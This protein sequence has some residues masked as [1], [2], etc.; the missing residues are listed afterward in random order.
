MPKTPDLRNEIY[1]YVLEY[2]KTRYEAN[3][4][5]RIKRDTPTTQNFHS[6][7]SIEDFVLSSRKY[8]EAGAHAGKDKNKIKITEVSRRTIRNAV[9]D[10]IKE[11]KIAIFKGSYEFVPHMEESLDQHP[12]LQIAEKIDIT[13]GVPNAMIVLSVAPEYITAVCNYLSALFHR[14]DIVFIPTYNKILCMN[15]LPKEA[16]DNPSII[17]STK[18]ASTM[19][20]ERIKTALHQFNY[21]YPNFRYKSFYEFAYHLHHNPNLIEHLTNEIKR[22]K[23]NSSTY[24]SYTSL[25]RLLQEYSNI[26]ANTEYDEAC[27]DDC[28]DSYIDTEGEDRDVYEVVNDYSENDIESEPIDTTGQEYMDNFDDSCHAKYVDN[29]LKDLGYQ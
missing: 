22:Q 27:W 3:L 29:E 25:L 9:N 16:L 18:N 14:G 28:F 6:I 19:L 7:K 4:K 23:I 5:S 12:I 8:V 2:F 1:N 11:G 17:E 21:H 15:V 10:L 13:I 20:H 26:A 24:H